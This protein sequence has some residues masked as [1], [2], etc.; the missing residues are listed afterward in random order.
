[1]K[2]GKFVLS[3]ERIP[4]LVLISVPSLILCFYRPVYF[5]LALMLIVYVVIHAYS[6]EKEQKDYLAK[7]VRE[8]SSEFD[9]VSKNAIFNMPFPL[10]LS[11]D[12][13]IIVWHNTPFQKFVEKD[14]LVGK[15]LKELFPPLEFEKL[16]F[17]EKNPAWE[18]SVSLSYKGREYDVHYEKVDTRTSKS[19][20]TSIV[21]HYFVD[22]TDLR[23]AENTLNDKRMVLGLVYVDNY[24]DIRNSTSDANRT[25]LFA[26][27]DNLVINAF[28]RLNGAVRKYENDKYM[29][30]MERWIYQQIESKKFELLDQARELT[31]GNA[32]PVTLSIGVCTDPVAPNELYAKAK[33]AI[34]VALGRGGDQAVVESQGKFS[35]Y[36]GKS[37]AV[38]KRNKVKARVIAF[39][40][41]QL[42]ESSDNVF[43]MGHRNPDMDSIGSAIGMLRVIQE[44][45]KDGYLLTYGSNPSIKNL[46]TALNE[47]GQEILLKF[48]RPEDAKDYISRNSLLVV[49]DNHKPSFTECPE[50]LDWISR[51]VVIDHHRRGAE[52]ISDPLLSY[53]EPYASST[54]ELVTEILTYLNDKVNMSKMEAECLLAGITVDTKNFTFQTGVRTFEAA[55]MLKR[56][57]ADTTRVSKFFRDDYDNVLVKAKVIES[58]KVVHGNIAIATLENGSEEAVLIAAEAANELLDIND[59]EA[60]FVIVENNKKLHV[61]GRS[62]GH[63]S[64]QLILERLGGGGHLTSAGAQF[65]NETMENAVQKV[66]ASIEEYLEEERKNEDNSV[67]GR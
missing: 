19:D 39:G 66:M 47:D 43:V 55:S 12:Q 34:N 56:C 28:Q 63:I 57:G 21:M 36:G 26:E 25:L 5:V 46:Y 9:T 48:M 24:D 27:V 52:F 65:E 16:T 38:E 33:A 45:G 3:K 4:Y 20:R 14:V 59:I 37:K 29:I 42:I 40:L 51:T 54:S 64:V 62:Y 53:V 30:V 61:S 44:C 10:V 7:E 23:N 6:E 13:G 22:T 41:K 49:V 18:Q 60:S 17:D 35:F 15:S 8:L 31:F 11:D 58:S 50:V 67:K 1:M 32:I 2:F